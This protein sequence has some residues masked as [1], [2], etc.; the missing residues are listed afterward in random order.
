MDAIWVTITYYKFVACVYRIVNT[1]KDMASRHTDTLTHLPV[2]YIQDTDTVQKHTGPLTY[3]S[4]SAY[5][6]LQADTLY[7]CSRRPCSSKSSPSATCML[8]PNPNTAAKT[9]C[10]HLSHYIVTLVK[11][12]LTRDMCTEEEM[13]N[14]MR[15]ISH[16]SQ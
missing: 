2:K 15:K 14:H 1:Y 16:A 5:K 4:A 8:G 7:Y 12:I 10:H 13:R 3:L 9:T 6:L 11:L